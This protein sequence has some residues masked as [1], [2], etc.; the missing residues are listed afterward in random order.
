MI[1]P[2]RHVQYH[3]MDEK[4]SSSENNKHRCLEGAEGVLLPQYWQS[5][6]SYC[7]WEGQTAE[8]RLSAYRSHYSTR[9]EALAC[10]AIFL[11]C[12]KGHLGHIHQKSHIKDD[13]END[14][15]G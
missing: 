14:L 10:P 12:C 2:N 9:G 7:L 4:C 15:V 5:D 1:V 3:P 13:D 8:S 11:T 6:V